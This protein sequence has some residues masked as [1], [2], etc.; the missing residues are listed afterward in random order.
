MYMWAL[1][2]WG[3]TGGVFFYAKAPP[4]TVHKRTSVRLKRPLERESVLMCLSLSPSI[5]LSLPFH[6]FPLLILIII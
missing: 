5:Y 4:E 6:S 2:K 3:A 1:P